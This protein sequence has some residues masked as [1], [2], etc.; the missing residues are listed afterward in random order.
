MSSMKYV[1]HLAQNYRAAELE[2]KILTAEAY[3][4]KTVTFDGEILPI[5]RAKGMYLII[6]QVQDR[7]DNA[8]LDG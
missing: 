5:Q 7:E 2:S 4:D 8:N 1:L 6:K 3:N